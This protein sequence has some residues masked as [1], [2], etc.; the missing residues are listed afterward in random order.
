MEIRFRLLVGYDTDC[1][2][3]LREIVYDIGLLFRVKKDCFLFI[4]IKIEIKG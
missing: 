2:F 3:G 1:Y 4:V